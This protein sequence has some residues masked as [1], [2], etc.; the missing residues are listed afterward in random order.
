[1]E[2]SVTDQTGRGDFRSVWLVILTLEGLGVA[3]QFLNVWPI[4]QTHSTALI[5]SGLIHLG[6]FG[7]LVIVL[8]VAWQER[9][10]PA[11]QVFMLAVLM[12]ASWGAELSIISRLA[13]R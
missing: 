6:A 3:M 5:G 8:R 13:T 4:L 9:M 7:A 12:L 2:P 1:M 11:S 10:V